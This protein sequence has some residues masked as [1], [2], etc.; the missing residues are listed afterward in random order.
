MKTVILDFETD[1]QAERFFEAFS[2]VNGD[3]DILLKEKT[4]KAVD[5]LLEFCDVGHVSTKTESAAY[6][7]LAASVS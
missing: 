7:I 4:E 5:D 2:G 6:T 3:K 1:E